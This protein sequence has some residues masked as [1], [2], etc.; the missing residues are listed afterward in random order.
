MSKPI[1]LGARRVEDRDPVQRHGAHRGR[2]GHF[3][4]LHGEGRPGRRDEQHLDLGGA[5]HVRGCGWR[6]QTLAAHV[7][8]GKC[9][10]HGVLRQDGQRVREPAPDLLEQGRGHVVQERQGLGRVDQ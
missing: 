9:C 4:H 7:E 5:E 1:G 10:A 6:D 3:V 8:L 2:R